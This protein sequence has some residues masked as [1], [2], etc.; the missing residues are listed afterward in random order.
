MREL[1]EVVLRMPKGDATAGDEKGM[2]RVRISRKHVFELTSKPNMYRAMVRAVDL[3]YRN[4]E[5]QAAVALILS[6]IEAM[7]GGGDQNCRNALVGDFPEL[8]KEVDPQT[9]YNAYRNGLLHLFAPKEKYALAPN[10][11]NVLK[12]SL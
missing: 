11:P 8:C 4:D 12:C 10:G 6:Y 1:P 2:K 9:F 5:P 7:A 3:L